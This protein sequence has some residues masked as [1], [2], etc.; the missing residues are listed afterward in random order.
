MIQLV[1]SVSLDVRR[2]QLV[3]QPVDR[4]W[5]WRLDLCRMEGG[6]GG[7]VPLLGGMGRQA[8]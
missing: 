3:T 7:M 2:V 1:G 6:V 5:H 4:F 8:G